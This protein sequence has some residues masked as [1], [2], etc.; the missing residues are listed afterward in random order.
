MSADKWLEFCGSVSRPPPQDSQDLMIDPEVDWGF[1]EGP[2]ARLPRGAT[3]PV[4]RR[5]W[6]CLHALGS[7]R[8]APLKLALRPT[9]LE[10][11]SESG[12]A[13]NPKLFENCVESNFQKHVCTK[14]L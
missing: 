4:Q 9:E 12:N 6:I 3:A 2:R 1:G 13:P 11:G 5:G 14:F 10:L 7:T 8:G